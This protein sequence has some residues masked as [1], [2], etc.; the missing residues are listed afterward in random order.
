MCT[1]CLKSVILSYIKPELILQGNLEEN[2]Q[3]MHVSSKLK[4]NV[5]TIKAEAG[6]KKAIVHMLL[7]VYTVTVFS[8]IP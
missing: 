8:H 6:G 7:L 3:C 1:V 4:K 2:T 5:A